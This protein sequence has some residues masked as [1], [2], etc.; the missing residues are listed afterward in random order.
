MVKIIGVMDEDPFD[1]RT[2]SG[3]SNYFFSALKQHGALADAI[4]AEAGSFSRRVAQIKSFNPDMT[5]WKFK[6]HL[7]TGLFKAMSAVA[8]SKINALGSS[9]DS[10]LQVGAWYDLI[11]PNI[12][13][14]S[15]H[16]GNLAARLASPFGYPSISSNCINKAL[17]YEKSLYDRLNLI[18]PMS[19]WLADSFVSD[20]GADERKVIPV[21]A[22]INLPEI[23]DTSNRDYDTKRILMVGKDFTRKG[24]DTLLEAFRKVKKSIPDAELRFIGPTLNNLPD[25]VSCTGF[26]QKN[27][28]QDLQKLLLEYSQ[29]RVFVIPSLYEPFGISFVE[30][31]AHRVPCIG[32]NI[33]AM[34]EI[35][36]H[37]KTGFL[38]TPKDS[39]T[40]ASYL[41]ELLTSDEQCKEMGNAGYK[42]Y[43]ENYTW[44]SVTE[45]I[46]D[47][48]SNYH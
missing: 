42:R 4:S 25:G 29:A 39:D 43:I 31:M 9:Y 24:G 26:L 15:Y 46:I 19:Q 10:I 41:L 3:S 20:F 8:K 18:F 37:E 21:G 48:I 27:N 7:N 38:I 13:N 1:Y 32:T 22:G 47:A 40:L 16:D 33:C 12:I 2:W 44:H 45:K 34:P 23:L 6:Y 35:I 5:K 28:P 14:V 11:D 17:T 36:K 30:A